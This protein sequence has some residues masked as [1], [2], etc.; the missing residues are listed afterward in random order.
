VV[1]RILAVHE[2]ANPHT[3]H[4]VVDLDDFSDIARSGKQLFEACS[5]QSDE[6]RPK[7]VS[8][9]LNYQGLNWGVLIQRLTGPTLIDL[10]STT[11]T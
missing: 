1:V 10:K 3:D 11:G 2:S 7:S 6:L 9:W 8:D 4:E 5:T